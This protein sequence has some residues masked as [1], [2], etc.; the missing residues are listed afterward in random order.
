[1]VDQ[2]EEREA[3]LHL[4]IF[5]V[6]LELPANDRYDLCLHLN[7]ALEDVHRVEEHVAL[8]HLVLL[9]QQKLNSLTL[10][11]VFLDRESF[12]FFFGL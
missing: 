1:M 4:Q 3:G 7:V 6:V 5:A 8:L 12:N 11:Q 10:C 9:S 2:V